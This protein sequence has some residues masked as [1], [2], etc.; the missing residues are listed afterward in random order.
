MKKQTR[1]ILGWLGV[2][3]AHTVMIEAEQHIL[4]TCRTVSCL[5]KAVRAFAA[6]DLGAKMKAIEDVRQ[7]ERAADELLRKMID[8]LSEGVLLP[9]DREDLMRMATSL[10]KIADTTN[11]AARLLAFI[12]TRLPDNV[13]KNI[14][15]SAEQIV[16]GADKLRE[17]IHAAG[18]NDIKGA[19]AFSAEVERVEHEADDQK[20][21]LIDA[22][23]H[24]N[25]SPVDLLLSYNLAEALEAVTDRIAT[26]SDLV[27]LVSVTSD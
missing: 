14:L 13:M 7:S 21:L 4:E 11:R 22:I 25:L 19:L 5:G 1:N 26:T 18:K 15:V 3:E 6:N 9:P 10:D 16:E 12:D 20:R 17:A 8:E 2:A 23:I 27:K 24:A